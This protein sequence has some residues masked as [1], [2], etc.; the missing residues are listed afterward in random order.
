MGIFNRMNVNNSVIM[1]G[2]GKTIVNGV[3]YDVPSGASVSINNGKVYI[4]GQEITPDNKE[5]VKEINITIIGNIEKAEI[6][7]NLTVE[8]NIQFAN[9][10]NNLVVKGDITGN[11]NAS[12][13]INA[14]N[15]HGNAMAGNNIYK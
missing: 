9:A 13:N 15:I 12:N 11:A 2:N 10:G 7:N 6:A 8:G 3:E 1:S 14:N 5:A 4:N